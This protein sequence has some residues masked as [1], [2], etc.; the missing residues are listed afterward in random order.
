MMSV[1]TLNR[2]HTGLK[3]GGTGPH[4]IYV[5]EQPHFTMRTTP[6]ESNYTILA[7]GTIHR[8]MPW[9]FAPT[10]RVQVMTDSFSIM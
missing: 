4:D 3:L 6:D 10:W 5:E 1:Y 2:G 7:V 8:G 9:A